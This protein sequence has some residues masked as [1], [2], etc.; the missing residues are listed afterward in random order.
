MFSTI[1]GDSTAGS[2][3]ARRPRMPLTLAFLQA[4]MG[5]TRLPGKVL[6]RM[7][8]KSVLER[9]VD[10]LRAA[11][12][13]DGVV[14]LTTTLAEDDAVAAEA[15][16]L[17]AASFRGPD[18]DVLARFRQA[19]VFFR[20]DIIV[21]ATADNPLIDIGSVDR[22]VEALQTGALDYCMER[23]LPVGAATEA[24]T[25]AALQRVDCLG[26]MPHHREHVTIYVKEHRD[27][28]LAA[29]PDPPEELRLPGVRITIDTADD[30]AFVDSLLEGI[31]DASPPR[32]L[33]AYLES[34]P[35]LISR[36]IP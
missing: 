21:R 36:R 12:T 2:A 10:R 34:A 26:R 16:R 4:R 28:F 35:F 11:S 29:F 31:P 19:A 8:G 33:L 18:R 30:F 15:H 20:P 14:I 6:L 22:I 7:H 17:G 1:A 27:E 23:N 24:I 9:A 3:E 25:S 5:S 32:P 13:L